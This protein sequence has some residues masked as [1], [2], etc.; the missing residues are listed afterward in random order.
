MYREFK[1]DPK[2][3]GWNT[4]EIVFA[5]I[6]TGIMMAAILPRYSDSKKTV[7]SQAFAER[8]VDLTSSVQD[9]FQGQG[10]FAGL[11]DAVAINANAV[12]QKWV[13]GSSISTTFG[14][15]VN[16]TPIS[17]NSQFRVTFNN[18]PEAL[19]STLLNYTGVGWIG[20]TINGTSIPLDGNSVAAASG[21]LTNSNTIAITV[22]R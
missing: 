7:E 11:T 1:R 5:L 19:A 10:N 16:L 9:R 2:R 12:P 13:S 8:A 4:M 6:I 22:G 15:A 3:Q 20:M 14:G 18:V 21:A 17:S